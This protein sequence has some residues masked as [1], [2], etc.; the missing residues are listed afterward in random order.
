VKK[1]K[2]TNASD[3]GRM[4]FCPRSVSLEKQGKKVTADAKRRRGAGD[5]A[6]ENFNNKFASP[7]RGPC[8]IATEVFGE[9]HPITESFRDY[10]DAHLNSVFGRAFI[11]FY[12]ATS[13]YLCRV[14]RR[15]NLA[16]RLVRKGLLSLHHTL[17]LRS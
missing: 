3:I 5:N 11:A 2:Y 16:R 1:Q 7:K 15:S 6:H 10:R 13:P 12:Y 4:A 17:R 9:S 14:L 8:F